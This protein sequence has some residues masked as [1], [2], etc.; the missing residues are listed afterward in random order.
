MGILKAIICATS[1]AIERNPVDLEFLMP[2]WSTKTHTFLTSWGEFSPSTED[3]AMLILLPLFGEAHAIGVALSEEDQKKVE[4][5]NKSLSSSKYLSNKTTYLSW[6]KYFDE[7]VGRNSQFQ[8]EAFLACGSCT[9][10]S[11]I[12]LKMGFTATWSHLLTY[13]LRETD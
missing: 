12:C 4:L 1:I 5:L 13:S 11:Q 7:G 6:V 8:I 2:Q 3:V 10:F 9:L